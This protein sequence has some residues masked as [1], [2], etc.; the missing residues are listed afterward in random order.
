MDI[1][2]DS[3]V[4]S[5]IIFTFPE[6]FESVVKHLIHLN[7]I[8]KY[9]NNKIIVETY[10]LHHY[11]GHP[12]ITYRVAQTDHATLNIIHRPTLTFLNSNK[13]QQNLENLTTP[14]RTT[15]SPKTL[16]NSIALNKTGIIK[17]VPTKK[18]V[19][20]T[21]SNKKKST[22]TSELRTAGVQRKR[23]SKAAKNDSVT[24][25]PQII[26]LELMRTLNT[27]NK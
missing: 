3:F 24:V 11:G 8:K 23:K 4:A 25:K 18:V 13:P 9:K 16:Y 10:S 21:Q 22:K 15:V 26:D 6:E 27:L 7:Y 1:V 19:V 12:S 17:L 5:N 2:Q 20:A 14:V